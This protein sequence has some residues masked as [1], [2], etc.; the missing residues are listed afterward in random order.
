M[1]AQNDFLSQELSVTEAVGDAVAPVVMMRN[2][3]KLIN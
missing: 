2:L 3:N 1:I